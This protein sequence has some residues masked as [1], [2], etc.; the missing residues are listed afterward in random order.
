MANHSSTNA[1]LPRTM[2][3]HFGAVSFERNRTVRDLA[4]HEK[5]EQQA[6]NEVQT[7]KADQ[8]KQHGP[9]VDRRTGALR[10]PHQSVDDPR[11][12]SELRGHPSSSGRNVGKRK[13]E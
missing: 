1:H 13:R 4:P 9:G 3:Q 2:R 6:K 7:S 5:Q 12:T 11:L 8:G 10:R